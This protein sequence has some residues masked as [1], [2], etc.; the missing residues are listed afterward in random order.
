[1]DLITYLPHSCGHDAVFT[2]VDH[3]SKYVIFVPCSTSKTALDLAQLFYDNIVYK[4]GMPVNIFSNIDSRFL[5]KNF[6][7]V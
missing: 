3:F 2:V 6:G 5:S 1:M 4:F 7:N